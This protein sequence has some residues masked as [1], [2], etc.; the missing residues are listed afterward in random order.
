MQPWSDKETRR[1]SGGHERYREIKTTAKDIIR[2]L[3]QETETR[4]T[5]IYSLV[6]KSISLRGTGILSTFVYRGSQSET[7]FHC[8][9]RL[10]SLFASRS[11]NIAP[12]NSSKYL[13]VPLYARQTSFLFL[14]SRFSKEHKQVPFDVARQLN[15]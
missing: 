11:D 10:V 3:E 1:E 5:Y 7:T 9:L 15:D 2:T 14:A 6:N 12:M 4:N 13:H 8:H